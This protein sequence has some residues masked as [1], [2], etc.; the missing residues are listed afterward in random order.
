MRLFTRASGCFRDFA[1]FSAFLIFFNSLIQSGYGQQGVPDLPNGVTA[2]GGKGVFP[3]RRSPRSSTMPLPGAG[4]SFR[5]SAISIPAAP[6]TIAVPGSTSAL[7]QAVAGLSANVTQLTSVSAQALATSGHDS[8]YSPA[9][10][11]LHPQKPIS[12]IHSLAPSSKPPAK[13]IGKPVRPLQLTGPDDPTDPYIINEAAALNHNPQQIFNYVRDNIGYQAYNGSVRGA[14]GT[15]WS[16]SGNALDRSS[17]LVALLEASGYTAQYVT[18]TL[19]KA[20]AQPLILSMFQGQ[21]RVLGCLPNGSTTA[22]PANDPTLLGIAEAHY[23]VEYSS[24]S[25]GPFTDADTAFPTSQLGQVYGTKVSTSSTVPFGSVATIEIELDAETYSQASAAFAGNGISSTGVLYQTYDVSQLVGKPITIGQFV[26]TNTVSSVI[27]VT[28]N[29]YSPYLAIGEDPTNPAN[30]DI[31]TG[32]PFQE[33]QTTFPLGSEVLTGLFAKITVTDALGNS[34][35]YDK[36]LFDR[37]GFAARQGGTTQVN[38]GATST[39]ALSDFDLV[40]FNILPSLQDAT[41]VQQWGTVNDSLLAQLN[42]IVQQL[43]SDPTATLTPAQ[44]ALQQ[45]AT[46]LSRELTMN[47]QRALTGTFAAASD[48]VTTHF[49]YLWQV[50]AYFSLPRILAASTMTMDNGSGSGTIQT[51]FDIVNDEVQVLESPGQTSIAPIAYR[52]DRGITEIQLEGRLMQQYASA[53]SPPSNIT[54]IVAVGALDI[55]NQAISQG[56]GVTVIGPSNEGVLSGLNLPADAQ[57]RI[58]QALDA[59][60]IVETPNK[61]VTIGGQPRIAWLEFKTDGTVI[62]TQEDGSHQGIVEYDGLAGN[63]AVQIA[64]DREITNFFIGFFTGWIAGQFVFM[65]GYSISGLKVSPS[66]PQAV[67]IIITNAYEFLLTELFFPATDP[68]IIAGFKAGLQAASLFWLSIGVFDPPIPPALVAGT[69]APAATPGTSPGISVLIQPDTVFTLPV[70]GAQVPTVFDVLITNTGPTADTFNVALTNPP[71][72]FTLVD[73]LPTIL[74]PAGAQAEISVCAVPTG[75]LP[76]PGTTAGFTVGVTSTTNNS[77]TS[78]VPET[79]KVPTV[80]GAVL[81]ATPSSATTTAGTAVPVTLQIQGVGNAPTSL[82]LAATVD[83]NLKLA[84]LQTPAQ[85]NAGQTITQSLTITPGSS[86]PLNSS[87]NVAITGTFGSSTPPQTSIVTIPITIEAKQALTASTTAPPAAAAGRTD[88]AST[89]SNLSGAITAVFAGCTPATLLALQNY[90]TNLSLEIG[91]A[92]GA[93]FNGIYSGIVNNPFSEIANATCSTYA[94]G[95]TDLNTL[96]TNIGNLFNSPAAYPFQLALTPVSVVAQPN[97]TSTFKIELQNQSQVPQTYTFAVSGIPAGLGGLN[98]TSITLAPQQAV[99]LGVASDPAVVISQTSN[100]LQAFSFTVTAASTTFPAA[101]QSATSSVTLRASVLQ[102]QDVKAN[103]G[104]VNAGGSVDVAADIANTVNAPT[105]VQASLKVLNP[106]N[107]AVATAG[108]VSAT[109]SVSDVLTSID[110]GQVTIPTGSPNGNYTLAVTLTDPKG[111]PLQGGTGSGFLLV[112]SP[113]TANLIVSPQTV[114]EVPSTVLNTLTVTPASGAPTSL[115]LVGSVATASVAETVALNGNTAYVCDENEVSVVDVTNPAKPTL[116]TTALSSYITNASNIHC[117]IQQGD[118]VIFSDTSST[119]IGNNPGFLVF[120]LSNPKSPNLLNAIPFDKRFVGDP[121]DYLGNTA[122]LYTQVVFSQFGFADGQGGDIISVDLSD[123]TKPT[124]LGTLSQNGDPVYG[125]PN[126]FFGAAVYNPQTLLVGSSTLSGDSFTG[127]AGALDTIDISNPKAISVSNQVTVNTNG[128]QY[129][130]NPQIQGNILVAL[131]NTG[132]TS[133]QI[134]VIQ[135]DQEFIVVFDISNPQNPVLLSTTPTNTFCCSGSGAAILGPNEFLFGGTMTAS[136]SGKP[137]LLLVDTTNPSKPVITPLSV[138]V[139]PDSLTIRGNYLYAPTATGLS[140]YSVPGTQLNSLIT[141]YTATV[142]TSNTGVVTYNP[143]S[144]NVAPTKITPGSGFDTIEWVNPGVSTLTWSSNVTGLQPAQLA[145]VDQGGTVS[146]TS[147]LGNGTVDLG[148]VDINAD[149]IISLTPSSQ[150]LG[151]S[152]FGFP[153]G[154][155][156]TAIVRNPTSAAVTYNLTLGGVPLSWL[157]GSRYPT[158]PATVTVPALGAVSL[159]FDLAPPMYVAAATYPFE[160]IASAQGI[161]GAVQGTLVY[162][163]QFVSTPPVVGPGAPG[164]IGSSNVVIQATPATVTTGAGSTALFELSLT[165]VGPVADTF[166]VFTSTTGVNPPNIFG[167]FAVPIAILPGHTYTGTL[168]VSV[169]AGAPV[170]TYP[171]TLTA[172]GQ[173]GGKGTGQAN[174]NVVANG[175]GLKVSNNS[176]L[177][178][179]TVQVTVTNTGSVS[180]TFALTLA[181]AGAAVS[182]L[183]SNSVALAAGANQNVNLTIV[184]PTFATQGSIPLSVTA[185]SKGNSAVRFT[186]PVTIYVPFNS[187]VTAAF[188]PASQAA[189]SSGPA[190]FP[191]LVQNTGSYQDGYSATITGTTNAV[192]ASFVGLDGNPTQTIAAFQVPAQATAQLTLHV[193]GDQAGTVT[194]LIASLNNFSETASAVATL[195][196][197]SSAFSAPNASAVTGLTTPVHRLAVLDAS[198]STDTNKP[199]LPLTYAWTLT[200]APAGSALTTASIGF[201]TSAKATFRPDVTGTWVFAVN[202]SNGHKSAQATSTWQAA[203]FPP[204]AVTAATLNVPTGSFAFLDGTNSYDPDGQPITF[205]WTLVSAPNGSAVTSANIDNAQTP[206][207]F[208]TPDVAGPYKL[209]LIVAD[210]SLSSMPVQVTVNAGA[211]G[212]LTPNANAGPSQNVGVSQQVTMNG[213]GSDPNT[214][215]LSLSYQWTFASVPMGSGLANGS[216]SSANSANAKFTPDVAGDYVLNLVVSNTNGA[217]QPSQVNIYAFTGNISPNASAGADQFTTPTSTV[218]LSS[219]GSSDPDNGPLPLAYIWW[220]NSLPQSSAATLTHPTSA[221]PQFDA[222]TSGYFIGRVEATD[223]LAS[224]FANKLV[225]SAKVCDADANGVINQTDIELIQ[226]AIGQMVLPGDPRDYYKTGTITQTDVT[227]CNN[228]IASASMLQVSPMSFTENLTTGGSAVTQ[229]LQISSSGNALTFNVMSNEPWLTVNIASGSTASVSTVIAQVN[230]AGLGAGKYVGTLM[231]TPGSG[232]AQAVTVTLNLTAPVVLSQPSFVSSPLLLQFSASSCSTSAMTGTF[233]LSS[234]AGGFSYSIA[235]SVSWLAVSP[236]QGNSIYPLPITVTVNSAGLTPGINVALLTIS[237]AGMQSLE[238]PVSVTV[239]AGALTASSASLSFS[240]A[241]GSAAPAQN[242]N[243]GA[244]TP[245]AFTAKTDQPWLTVSASTGTTPL[246]IVVTAT[247]ATLSEGTYTGH[248]TVASAGA[249]NSPLT[250]PVTFVVSPVFAAVNSASMLSGPLAGG[251][252]FTIFGGG[253]ANSIMSSQSLPLPVQ[254]DGVKVTIGSTAIP[255]LYVSPTQI[256]AQMPYGVTGSVQA[257]VTLNGTTVT[258]LTIPIADVAP[259][260]FI[261]PD[262]G[263]HGAVENADYSVNSPQHPASPGDAL[264]AFF[265]G[266]GAVNP[267]V[268]TGAGAPLSPLSYVSA[269]PI[270]ATIGGMPATV[271]FTGLTPTLAGVAQMNLVVPSLAPGNYPLILTIAG[272]SA[273]AGIVSVGP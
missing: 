49:A 83:P 91:N 205:A 169:P 204:V 111:N 87:L 95:V 228:L 54:S 14:R 213:S 139:A 42:T 35:T 264:L 116:I 128:I 187:S 37:I 193:T 200:S 103:P 113:V 76:A 260:L 243:I 94:Q 12:R 218:T 96:I 34:T 177:A 210:P 201:P 69:P 16:K 132:S 66:F 173:L 115:D 114:S 189:P 150:T 82:T 271:L 125:G 136:T 19:T 6:G 152:Y 223:G 106:S 183:S 141:G 63:E 86:A 93:F 159:P 104:F 246:Q 229:S 32:T 237:G 109:L 261:L 10:F 231:F 148:P 51:E 166:S 270:T 13:A 179:A 249:D 20:Q 198:A 73:S 156:Y 27:S 175:V 202:V 71:A 80:S 147:T 64:T 219:T 142:Q 255:L 44:S 170:G 268:A 178:P 208:F 244:C 266:Q 65:L 59:G 43:P 110:F 233:N 29:T 52:T 234:T 135:N 242:L 36:T 81:S 206:K 77:I 58:Q 197:G 41:M 207:P 119:T 157:P 151:A 149:Q 199:A 122:Y 171:L 262:T 28:T 62:D 240:A 248:V 154:A 18:G 121:I 174:V 146:F 254:L 225:V 26:S 252:L 251:S 211:N 108:P 239:G 134:G 192:E 88:I 257:T 230:P 180:D 9:G 258:T 162:N 215:A 24:S 238:I 75:T 126:E 138:T 214:P 68:V 158:L 117:S 124:I 235:S 99:P 67:S 38:I 184:D 3:A 89:L 269:S 164:S 221:N 53:Q 140:I 50:Q 55:L 1:V 267:A 144:F 250:I 224:G 56:I 165:N 163:N 182:T 181:G 101:T 98:T 203:D 100:T 247:A 5:T 185:T 70:G 61:T 194:V 241:T 7:P 129:I 127:G 25:S 118:L 11:R 97:S 72:G 190:V 46:T 15:L 79:F 212:S 2:A 4:S 217:S 273:N 45:Q 153:P 17:L 186:A 85:V 191:L 196:T 216:I 220:L 131:A 84:G 48:N 78:S 172:F 226:A 143:S 259:G 57:A 112:G 22:D 8:N 92:N 155:S 160:V 222:D 236:S 195:T 176:P 253:L 107:T 130:L 90:A 272:K 102:V 161:Y 227:A 30:D 137:V 245:L 232:T 145:T 39:P 167:S 60:S 33:V 40:T 47:T 256:N 209:Q 265:T 105:A 133:T 123:V 263:G 188:Q 168:S 23:W 120:G 21:Y 74:I 31:I